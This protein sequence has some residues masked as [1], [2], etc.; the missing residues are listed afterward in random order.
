MS[1]VM[2]IV[3]CEVHLRHCKQSSMPLTRTDPQRKK[4]SS[5]LL[6]ESTCTKRIP[7]RHQWKNHRSKIQL[8]KFQRFFEKTA[9]FHSSTC[10]QLF[11]NFSST[12]PQL[13]L[14]KI[15]PKNTIKPVKNSIFINFS[16]STFPQ[17]FL[18]FSSRVS[19]LFL[20]KHTKKQKKRSVHHRKSSF[21]VHR[22]LFRILNRVLKSTKLHAWPPTVPKSFPARRPWVST[23][24]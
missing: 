19:T 17:L 15:G 23:P 14:I 1:M 2:M 24:C 16:S 21:W 6:R 5:G 9:R 13:F 10:P 3:H 22:Q 11:L 4:S 20:E 18:N 7:E 12:F 8:A